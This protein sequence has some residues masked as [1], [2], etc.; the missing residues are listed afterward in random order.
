M[1]ITGGNDEHAADG[2]RT[3]K[4]LKRQALLSA[5]MDR[6]ASFYWQGKMPA[7]AFFITVPFCLRSAVARKVHDSYMALRERTGAWSRISLKSVLD[8]A[9]GLIGPQKTRI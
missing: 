3:T 6:A 9:R 4:A 5:E 7:A 8:A 1:I 2:F